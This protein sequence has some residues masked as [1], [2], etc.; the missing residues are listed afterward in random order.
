MTS[1][2]LDL[3]FNGSDSGKTFDLSSVRNRKLFER[4][5]YN[6]PPDLYFF[7]WRGHLDVKKQDTDINIDLYFEEYKRKYVVFQAL[8]NLSRIKL[9]NRTIDLFDPPTPGK[10][11]RT[12]K[13][14]Y[15]EFPLT[16]QGKAIWRMAE[17]DGLWE[18]L[19]QT[20][21]SFLLTTGAFTEFFY[22]HYFFDK[23]AQITEYQTQL[24]TFKRRL[25]FTLPNEGEIIFDDSEPYHFVFFTYVD[26]NKNFGRLLKGEVVFLRA[27]IYCGECHQLKHLYFPDDALK[28]HNQRKDEHHYMCYHEDKPSFMFFIKP[29]F[30][31]LR[32][33]NRRS[34]KTVDLSNSR[35]DIASYQPDRVHVVKQNSKLKYIPPKIH[36]EVEIVSIGRVRRAEV[37]RFAYKRKN[38][39][40]QEQLINHLISKRSL[41]Q[42]FHSLSKS[43]K[44]YNF[45]GYYKTVS[46]VVDRL[47]RKGWVRF[48][49][50]PQKGVQ[51]RCNRKSVRI[52]ERG[53]QF[54]DYLVREYGT[55]GLLTAQFDLGSAYR[56]LA[57]S[58]TLSGL[59]LGIC[60]I[61][62]FIASFFVLLLVLNGLSS[63]L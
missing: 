23:E 11:A 54:W 59:G 63:F 31:R 25:G 57:V 33:V 58:Q 24:K 30:T 5:T 16:P 19:L 26:L 48:S 6:F 2:G 13:I 46:K 62:F 50:V 27:S 44:S 9:G 38:W 61:L 34:G 22:R 49:L 7:C 51:K 17:E 45:Q 35:G 10:K 43:D 42:D 12:H 53:K 8:F 15:Q 21:K 55:K 52:T 1:N 4:I 32:H 20:P 37:L 47:F 39:F 28:V 18:K 40:S 14:L 29:D 56:R 41:T 3:A 60:T 36:R